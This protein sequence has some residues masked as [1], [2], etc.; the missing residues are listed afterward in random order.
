VEDSGKKPQGDREL[1]YDDDWHP[2]TKR[3]TKRPTKKPWG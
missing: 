2:P 3:P 1:Y